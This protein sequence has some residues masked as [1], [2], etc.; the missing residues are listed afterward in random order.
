MSKEEMALFY[1]IAIVVILVISSIVIAIKNKTIKEIRGK[2]EELDKIYFEEVDAFEGIL[3]EK[4][5]ELKAYCDK[6][7]LKY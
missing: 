4:E 5:S 7:N 2:I 1:S 6:I 3:Q